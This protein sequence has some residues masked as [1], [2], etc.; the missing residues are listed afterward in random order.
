YREEL[1]RK[2][3]VELIVSDGGSK[4]STLEIAKCFANKVVVHKSSKRQTIAEGRN[5]GAEVATGDILIFINGDTIPNN[6]EKFFDFVANWAVKDLQCVALAVKVLPFPEEEIWK[7]KI[8]YF[9]HNNYVKFLNFVGL[10]MGRGEC[11]VVRREAFWRVGGYNSKIIAGED[12]DLYR[13]LAR[14]GRIKYVDNVWVYESPRRFRKLGYIKTIMR[15]LLNGIF[16]MIFGRSYS[17]NWEPI[18]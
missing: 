17:N 13:R 11:Q 18:R 8:F 9:L 4:D 15:W 12:F 5:R 1:L 3:S 16:V 2:Y 14:I 10:G 6:I 7:D